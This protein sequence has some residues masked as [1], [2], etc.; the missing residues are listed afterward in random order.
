MSRYAGHSEIEEKRTP[1]S[2]KVSSGVTVGDRPLLCGVGVL[3]TDFRGDGSGMFLKSTSPG[4]PLLRADPQQLSP[5]GAKANVSECSRRH[6]FEKRKRLTAN[7]ASPGLM[8]PQGGTLLSPHSRGTRSI[9]ANQR[10]VL[11]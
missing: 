2:D 11:S 8:E 9:N 4:I 3:C 5:Q 7:P 6:S 1:K 10:A